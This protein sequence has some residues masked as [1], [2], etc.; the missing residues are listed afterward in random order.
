M[1]KADLIYI[2]NIREI[3]TYG[4]NDFGQEV[5]PRYKDGTPAHTK[6]I[7]NV[8]E[9]YNLQAGEFPFTSLRPIAVKSGIGEI[10][11]IYRDASNS[12]D[13]LRDKYG[14]KWWDEWDIGNRTIG[15]R[16]GATVLRW[17]LFDN[18]IRD[19]RKSPFSR[20]HIM[21]LL[22]APDMRE[23]G[24]LDPCCFMTT[25]QVTEDENRTRFLHLKMEQ[26]SNDYITAGHINKVQYVALQMLVARE[27]GMEV[28]TFTHAISNLHIYDRHFWAAEELIRRADDAV[29]TH[30]TYRPRLVLREGATLANAMPDDF[31]VVDYHPM[32][33][34]PRALEIAV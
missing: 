1:H 23:A 32:E 6:F 21:I 17:D 7:L 8:Q 4:Y 18:L 9:T 27:L 31:T 34:L 22:Q 16:Y 30:N 11:W 29:I 15:Q 3:D 24:G 33:K 26:R 19:L 14:V 20:R 13:L 28:G 2:Q 10:L 5:R 25:W 12:L